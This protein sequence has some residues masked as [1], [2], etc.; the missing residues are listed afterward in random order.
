MNIEIGA[1]S[2][3]LVRVSNSSSFDEINTLITKLRLENASFWVNSLLTSLN[4]YH[5]LVCIFILNNSPNIFLDLSIVF[6]TK[7]IFALTNFHI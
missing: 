4:T 6:E 1:S 5:F 2:V 3:L 7:H